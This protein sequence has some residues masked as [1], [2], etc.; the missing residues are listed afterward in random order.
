MASLGNKPIEQAAIEL[1]PYAVLANGDPSQ[2]EH[3]SKYL[4]VTRLK[5]IESRDPHFRRGDFRRKFSAAGFFTKDVIDEIKLLL[6]AGG[7]GHLCDLI[8]ELLADSP[9]TEHLVDELLHLALEPGVNENTRLLAGRCLI[10]LQGYNHR[11]YCA[12]LTSEASHTSLSITAE[13]IKTLGPETFGRDYLA[14]F[15]RVCA[16]LYP[17]HKERLERTIGTRYFVQR[18]ITGLDVA[19]IEWLLDDLT[20]DLTCKCGKECY[21]CDCLNGMSKIIGLMLDRHFE[22]ATPPFDPKRIWQWV[23][24]LNYHEGKS[25]NQSKAVKVLREEDSLR[26]GI[27]AHVLGKLTDRDLIFDTTQDKFNWYCHSGLAF[28]AND[29]KFVVDLAFES[30]NPELWVSFM[31]K[32]NYHRNREELGPDSLRQHMRQQALEK[33]SFMREW[34]KSNRAAA[35]IERKYRIRIFKHNRRMRR[36]SQKKNVIRIANIKYVQENREL[37]EGGRHWSLLVRFAYLV[38]NDPG[39]IEQEFGEESLVRNA[40]KNCLDFIAPQTPD[41]LKFAELQCASEGLH[42]ESILFAACL[43]IMNVKGSLEG[44]DL[45]L[46][47][48]LRTNLHMGYS[49]V[50][51]EEREALKAEVN[52]LIFPD[53]ESAE[54]FLRQYVEPQLAQPGCTNPE[55]WLLRSEEVFSHSRASLSIEWLR[56]FRGLALTP[57]DTLFE[58]A[59][60]HGNRD[61]LKKIIL[62]RCAE[63]ICCCPTPT[64]SEHIENMRTFWFV[65]AWYF[66]HRP[67]ETCWDWLKADKDTVF[68]INGHSGAM[69]RGD[70]P[71][72]PKLTPSKVEAVLEAFIDKWPKVN[73]PSTWGTGSPKEEDAYRFLT[74]I[75]WSINTCDPDDAIPVLDRL[76][77]NPSFTDQHQNLRSIHSA[78][79]RNKAL[80]DFEPPTPQEIVAHLDRDSVVTVEDLRQHVIQELQDLQ[81]AID[82]GEFNSS[83][84][85][86]EKG[87]RLGEV[88]ST[89]IIAERLNLR[90]EQQGI[91]VTLEHQLKAAKRSD[92]TVT[93][94]IGSKRRL[95]VTEVKGQWHDELYT[96]A[97]AQLH[98]RYSIHPDAEQQGIYLV[99]WFGADE[100]V[101][102]RITHTI[103]SAQELKSSIVAKLPLELT[104]LIDVFVLDVSKPQ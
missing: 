17:G 68:I 5:E 14:A 27:I 20:K 1:D 11:V 6:T 90:L 82:G 58:I 59:A 72:W 47:Q 4:L 19:I 98:E 103:K 66:L 52:R 32:H 73:L 34:V 86:Y 7:D 99:I 60:Q 65:R 40:L 89:E 95:L 38:L 61:D 9:A 83:D 12:V 18:L 56:R 101:A 67:P 79:V 87:E 24:N 94:M 46:L 76:I 13:A 37:V 51:E 69:N 44:V 43:E 29:Y 15:F 35:Q 21:E 8:L 10:G 55:I 57:L 80:R 3:S 16:N 54:N 39:I 84:R 2:L 48:A 96:A 104:G 64:G 75:V 31:A 71:Y 36:R 92:F 62:E 45:R 22:L 42:V 74:E 97:S 78:Q 70:H 53:A 33:S 30:D 26:Q 23:G 41:L 100:K 77:S 81:K 50:S 49:A 63:F 25:A 91:S 28:Q 93:K 88:R 85:F 102:G